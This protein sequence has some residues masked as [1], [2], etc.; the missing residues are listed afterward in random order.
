MDGVWGGWW[1]GLE[2]VVWWDGVL[3]EHDQWKDQVV[4]RW[5]REVGRVRRTTKGSGVRLRIL[6]DGEEG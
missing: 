5:E 1:R 3:E 6:V 4:K 2:T